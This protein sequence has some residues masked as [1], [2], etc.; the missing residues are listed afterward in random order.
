MLSLLMLAVSTPLAARSLG[1]IINGDSIEN[2]LTDQ[3]GKPGAGLAV[4]VDRQ[5]GHCLLCHVVDSIDEPFQGNLGPDLSCG[6]ALSDAQLRLRLVD[7]SRVNPDTVMPS[8]YRV[9]S[10]TQV[11]DEYRGRP[12]LAAQQIEDLIAFVRSLRNS[13]ICR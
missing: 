3:P 2:P 4:F 5:S 10:L 6:S 11:G 9:E 12:A 13:E 8:Y 1:D 7:S